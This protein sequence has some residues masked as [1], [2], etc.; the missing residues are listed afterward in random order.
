MKWRKITG[1]LLIIGLL[2]FFFNSAY[3][4]IEQKKIIDTQT[5]QLPN[6]SFQTQDNDT[7]TTKNISN[8]FT[9]IIVNYYNPQCEHCQYMATQI[10]Q[11]ASKGSNIQWLCITSADSTSI[12]EFNKKYGLDQ[13]ENLVMLKD[14]HLQFEKKFGTAVVPSFFIYNQERKLIKKIIGET[15]IENLLQ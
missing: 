3:K 14:S 1:L 8:N 9:K 4:K 5:Q 11:N 13:M 15:K 2:L 7:F 6:F 12:H 10:K